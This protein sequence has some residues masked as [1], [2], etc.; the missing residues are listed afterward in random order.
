MIRTF[1]GSQKHV[2]FAESSAESAK[3]YILKPVCYDIRTWKIRA[4]RLGR[5]RAHVDSTGNLN[6][7]RTCA[8][9]AST[10]PAEYI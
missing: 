7:R 9:T 1:R 5:N 3:A 4:I 8:R 2:Y 6:T 10:R